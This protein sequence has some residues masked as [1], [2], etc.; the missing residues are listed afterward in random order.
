M[1]LFPSNNSLIFYNGQL[2]WFQKNRLILFSLN[3][4]QQAEII[5]GNETQENDI[6]SMKISANGTIAACSNNK[7][8]Y[9]VRVC[10]SNFEL[11]GQYK[12]SKRLNISIFKPDTNEVIIGD[13]FGD[14]YLININS[15]HS[16]FDSGVKSNSLDGGS[17]D[18][19]LPDNNTIDTII[20][21]MGH[22]S[23][24]TCLITSYDS[25]LLFAGNKCG[26]I[27]ISNLNHIEH[28][29]S[30]LCGHSDAISS[31]CEINT[32]DQYHKLIVSSSLDKKI[33]LWDYLN[34]DEVDSINIEVSNYLCF[35]PHILFT[36][37]PFRIKIQ[38]FDKENFC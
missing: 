11:I 24:V 25:K 3:N 19:I 30:I 14:L 13:K 8:I 7:A 20:P 17:D 9:I 35:K 5:L 38:C 2:I 16:I 29:F 31:I 33:K 15:I 1:D 22:L 37:Y 21:K 18:E 26:K 36:V 6:V 4:S 34:G 28:T 23:T 10:N 27:W 12:H 32:I